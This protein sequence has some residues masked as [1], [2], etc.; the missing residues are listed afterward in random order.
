MR[1]HQSHLNIL[2]LSFLLICAIPACTTQAEPASSSDNS[3]ELTAAAAAT[4]AQQL[5]DEWKDSVNLALDNAFR[6]RA[7]E[8]G[9]YRMKFH[10][11][12]YKEADFND[13]DGLALYISLHGGGGTTAHATL[14][15]SALGPS[16]IHGTC[17]SDLS[18]TSFTV[19]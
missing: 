1:C 6:N 5:I 9:N 15:I 18:V 12:I 13:A 2:T 11:N 19:S 8:I 3:N 4:L 16:K 7:L 17:T 14:S 10:Y